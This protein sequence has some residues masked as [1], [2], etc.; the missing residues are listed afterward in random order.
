MAT[1]WTTNEVRVPHAASMT[2]L[3]LS[4]HLERLSVSKNENHTSWAHYFSFQGLANGIPL[5]QLPHVRCEKG[6]R[7][8]VASDIN[9]TWFTFSSHVTAVQY[10]RRK[11]HL[12]SKV[13]WVRIFK[14][15]VPSTTLHHR[16]RRQ[17][18][19][20]VFPTHQ[21]HFFHRRT[22]GL[23][24]MSFCSNTS[25]SDH[26]EMLWIGESCHWVE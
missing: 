8:Q 4:D 20:M 21:F 5:L 2:N 9:G 18:H 26:P 13:C 22:L 25:L 15:P 23:A 6:H 19:W 10:L 14:T 12:C 11:I 16:S 17:S 24:R 1:Y 3:L 7:I